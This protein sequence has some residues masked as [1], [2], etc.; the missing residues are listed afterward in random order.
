MRLRQRHLDST[1]QAQGEIHHARKAPETGIERTCRNP[2]SQTWSITL[3]WGSK[4]RKRWYAKAALGTDGHYTAFAPKLVGTLGSLIGQ[5]RTEA[6]ETGCAPTA[7]W[8]VSGVLNSPTL[9]E[10]LQ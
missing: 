1:A 3:T 9:S 5:L 4:E 10:L 6:G 7:V 8:A 2:P